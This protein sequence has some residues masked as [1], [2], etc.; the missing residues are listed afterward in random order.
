M[1][2]AGE[3]P[4]TTAMSSLSLNR[5]QASPSVNTDHLQTATATATATTLLDLPLEIFE[6]TLTYLPL[7]SIHNLALCNNDTFQSPILWTKILKQPFL[8]IHRSKFS[9][10]KNS[11]CRQKNALPDN[12]SRE[13]GPTSLLPFYKPHPKQYGKG[14]V[15]KIYSITTPL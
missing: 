4:P 5:D 11:P 3:N 7:S 10:A 13:Q 14:S 6:S 9:S 12:R 15:C 8:T 2:S 1:L